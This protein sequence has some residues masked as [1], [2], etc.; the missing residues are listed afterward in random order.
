MDDIS[1]KNHVDSLRFRG[2]IARTKLFIKITLLARLLYQVI[3][4]KAKGRVGAAKPATV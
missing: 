4:N 2:D 1:L 3:C